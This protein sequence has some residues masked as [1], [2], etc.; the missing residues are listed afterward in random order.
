MKELLRKYWWTIILI[1][2]VPLLVNAILVIDTPC[3]NFTADGNNGWL[4]FWGAYL[5]ALCPFVVLMITIWDNHKENKK[6]RNIQLATIEYQVSREDLITIKKSIADYMQSL[7]FLELD[8]IATRPNVNTGESLNKIFEICKNTVSSFELLKMALSDHNDE[9]GNEYKSSLSI[10]KNEYEGM[11]KD[12]GWVLDFYLFNKSK[13]DNK[14]LELYRKK[15]LNEFP[16]YDE[17]KRVWTI[18]GKDNYNIYER[19]TE[20]LKELLDRLDYQS[21]YQKSMEFVRYE[22]ERMDEKLK[23]VIK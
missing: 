22:K 3:P 15:E 5:G 6:D 10:F 19:G 18:V 14:E 9:K 13:V 16:V 23:E 11:I 1:I 20:I 4:G 17:S 12:F 7:N 2:I 21:I 8:I